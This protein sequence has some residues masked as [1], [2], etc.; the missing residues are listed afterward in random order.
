M[1]YYDVFDAEGK[2]IVKIPLFMNIQV[3]K[4]NRLYTIESDDAG[5]NVA[6]RYKVTWNY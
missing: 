4:K 5:Y 1:V 2:Y 3:F 6:K